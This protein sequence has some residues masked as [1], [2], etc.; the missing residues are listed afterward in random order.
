VGINLVA[1]VVGRGVE[2]APEDAG[3]WVADTTGA[4]VGTAVAAGADVAAGAVVG[5][6][7]GALV[8]SSPPHAAS[9]PVIRIMSKRGR[10][11][12]NANR[13]RTFTLLKNWKFI[14]HARAIPTRASGGAP[15]LRLQRPYSHVN[16]GLTIIFNLTEM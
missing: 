14:N 1:D 10:D 16:I 2:A 11:I 13:L 5:A 6:A 8:A 4:S 9:R 3:A 7:A 12:L 15:S